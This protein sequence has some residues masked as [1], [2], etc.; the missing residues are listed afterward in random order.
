M[1]PHPT[2]PSLPYVIVCLPGDGIGP[3]VMCECVKVLKAVD[4]GGNMLCFIEGL[5]GG[6][7]YDKYGCHLPNETLLLL[8][9]PGKLA[10]LLGS[11]GGPVDQ[12]DNPKWKDVEKNALLGLRKHLK[13]KINIRPTVVYNSLRYLSPLKDRILKSFVDIV[14]IRELSSGIYFGKHSTYETD[15]GTVSEDVMHYADTEI[16]VAVHHAFQVA[17]VKP[18]HKLCVVDKAN[19]LDCSRLWRKVAIKVHE[20]FS[21]VTLSFMYVDNAALQLIQDPC[22][23][24]VIVTSNLFGDILS[25]LAAG[26]PGSIGLMPSASLGGN[27]DLFEPAGGSAPDIAGLN[28]ANPIAQILS[29][30]MMLRHSFDMDKEARLIERV[31]RVVKYLASCL[32]TPARVVPLW[33]I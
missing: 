15:Q 27:V 17:Q 16:E 8:D 4:A 5:V 7:A 25:D 6:A 12:R 1:K 23:F 9:Q 32:V 31:V 22:A 2:S 30:A 33:N 3:E 19:V 20:Q 13:L 29:G 10:V 26:L 14:I 21:D 11:V 18:P 24:S 28:K